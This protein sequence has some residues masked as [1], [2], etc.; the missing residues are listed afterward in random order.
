MADPNKHDTQSEGGRVE[1]ERV[2]PPGD[3]T[4]DIEGI[5]IDNAIERPKEGQPGQRGPKEPD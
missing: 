5:E 2:K 4:P 1:P 3:E